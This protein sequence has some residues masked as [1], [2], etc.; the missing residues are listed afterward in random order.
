MKKIRF[1]FLFFCAIF[2]TIN[3]QQHLLFCTTTPTLKIRVLNDCGEILTNF[4]I[5]AE[6]IDCLSPCRR[7]RKWRGR[8]HCRQFNCLSEPDKQCVYDWFWGKTNGSRACQYCGFDGRTIQE[9]FQ[10]VEDG[11]N[12]VEQNIDN[13]PL[14]MYIYTLQSGAQT[15]T[16][17]VIKN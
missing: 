7:C 10:S 5:R 1:I 2:T 6:Q 11:S 12:T 4:P 13:L 8:N 9:I 3:A 17:K 14:G 16:G 15:L